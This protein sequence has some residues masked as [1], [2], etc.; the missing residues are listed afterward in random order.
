MKTHVSDFLNYQFWNFCFFCLIFN[1]LLW[2]AG[3]YILIIIYF[4]AAGH[5][6]TSLLGAKFLYAKSEVCFT[7]L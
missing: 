7:P 6:E 5:L 4:P 1:L 2:K 3:K